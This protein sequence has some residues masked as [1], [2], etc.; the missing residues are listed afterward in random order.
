MKVGTAA[1]IG[2]SGKALEGTNAGEGIDRL[3]V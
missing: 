3:M 2:L 1:G